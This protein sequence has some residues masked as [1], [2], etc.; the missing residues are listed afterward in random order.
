ME[1]ID[2]IL[3][4]NSIIAEEDLID[5]FKSEKIFPIKYVSLP[6][7][8][9][10]YLDV[11]L[12]EF[13]EYLKLNNIKNIYYYYEYYDFNSLLI[14]EEIVEK[15]QISKTDL[16]SIRID[17]EKY[18]K[19]LLELD[20]LNPYKIIIS[21]LYENKMISVLKM[22]D[23]LSN[24]KF[25]KNPCIAIES[26]LNHDFVGDISELVK[27]AEER[28]YERK[29][30]VVDE[31]KRKLF[32]YLLNNDAFCFC[33]NAKMRK[34]FM[35][36]LD[37]DNPELIDFLKIGPNPNLQRS[38]TFA[39]KVWKLKKQGYLNYDDIKEYL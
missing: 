31:K 2:F 15:S 35:N 26:F 6:H 30:S 13:L 18:N 14:T 22:N 28:M 23:W 25:T 38:Y 7:M 11:D 39:E 20:L 9:D 10:I 34:D 37:S 24:T 36:D 29:K 8:T 12:T 1:D 19:E 3:E 5:F 32:D 27:F 4:D 21:I 33:T 17:I 16:N